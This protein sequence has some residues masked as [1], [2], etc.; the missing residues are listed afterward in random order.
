MCAAEGGNRRAHSRVAHEDGQRL[1]LHGLAL[2]TIGRAA[3]GVAEAERWRGHGVGEPRRLRG[4]VH[5]APA[6]ALAAGQPERAIDI[7]ERLLAGPYYLSRAWLRIDPPLAP[8]AATR[9]S[10]D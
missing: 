7:L 10:S 1:V 4:I 3:E 8:C 5:A 6:R 2:A 9:G